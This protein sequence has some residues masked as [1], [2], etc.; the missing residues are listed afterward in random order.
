GCPLDDDVQT[1][2]DEYSCSADKETATEP[3]FLPQTVIELPPTHPL[4][5]KHKI[6]F[7]SIGTS[8]KLVNDNHQGTY[9][10]LPGDDSGN[11]FGGD[12][13]LNQ[14]LAKGDKRYRI[15]VNY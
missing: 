7:V 13:G 8:I 6:R 14:V 1:A 2:P 5:E 10:G 11:T 15:G 9:I 3:L 12:I 4:Y